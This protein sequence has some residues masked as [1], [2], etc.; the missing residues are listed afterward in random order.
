LVTEPWPQPRRIAG[1]IDFGDMH[2]GITVS[3]VAIAAAY[4]IL[5]KTDVLAA[6]AAVVHGYHNAFPLLETEIAV[7]YPLI[8]MRLAVSV[9]NSARRKPLKP[10]DPYVTISEAAAWEALELW[11]QIHPRFA[12]YALRAACSLAPMPC[13][14]TVTKWLRENGDGAASILTADLRNAR[15]V[16]LDLSV[17]STFLGADP[18]AAAAE[19]LKQRVFDEMTRAGAEVGIGRYDEARLLY[20][21]PLFG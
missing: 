2:H 20:S 13:E 1:V 17:G 16:V 7:L 15:S 21:S 8:G 12:H 14:K 10:N 18:D 19:L 4:A 5:A 3:E 11:A 6:A 9:T